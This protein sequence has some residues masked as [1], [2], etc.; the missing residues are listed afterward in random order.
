KSL[1]FGPGVLGVVFAIGGLGSLLGASMATR[2]TI[3]FGAGPALIGSLVLMASA[4]GMITLA[5]TAGLL[6]LVIMIGQQLGDAFWIYYESTGTSLRQVR[7]PDAMLGRINGTFE[8]IQFAG[9]LLGAGLGA[10]I[11]EWVGLRATILTGSGLVLLAALVLLASPVRAVHHLGSV[12]A[13]S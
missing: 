12:E 11:G 13:I 1:G 5:Q 4:M 7:T 9:L 3:R 8:N 10:A 2:V 6:A